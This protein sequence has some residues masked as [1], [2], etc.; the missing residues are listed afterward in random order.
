VENG[1]PMLP[2]SV[3]LDSSRKRHIAVTIGKMNRFF[4]GNLATKEV[5]ASSRLHRSGRLRSRAHRRHRHS[6]ADTSRAREAFGYEPKVSFHEGLRR[7][8]NWYRARTAAAK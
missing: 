1:I 6:L 3:T 2:R 8:L 5:S 4:D 7:T